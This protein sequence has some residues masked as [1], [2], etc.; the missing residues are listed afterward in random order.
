MF[1]Q[2]MWVR[3]RTNCLTVGARNLW[4]HVH[5]IYRGMLPP[6]DVLVNACYQRYGLPTVYI[7][8]AVRRPGTA[9]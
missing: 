1:E 9:R 5:S 2:D 6:H 4:L 8:C 7:E 3:T